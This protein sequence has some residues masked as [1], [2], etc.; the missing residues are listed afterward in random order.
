MKHKGL[1]VSKVFYSIQG[2][3]PTSGTPSVFLM[4]TGC[5]LNLNTY[6]K[7]TL[8]SYGEVLSPDLVNRLRQGAHLIF[9]G[10]EPLLQE[11][12]ILEFLHIFYAIYAFNPV[13]EIETN[14]TILP[15]KELSEFVHYWNINQRLSSSGEIFTARYNSD[16][17]SKFNNNANACFKFL[18][19]CKDDIEEMLKDFSEEINFKKVM[20]IPASDFIKRSVIESAMNLGVRYCNKI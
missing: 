1:I 13:V 12:Q 8:V 4:L 18:I 2:E 16:V 15:G 6:W 19:S 9:A 11:V 10:G 5:N 20:L 14:G 17:I 3:G 7:G